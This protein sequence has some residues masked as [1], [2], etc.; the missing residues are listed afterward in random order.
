MFRCHV[1]QHLVQTSLQ[2]NDMAQALKYIVVSLLIKTI[3]LWTLDSNPSSVFYSGQDF[4]SFK[5]EIP[6]Y[7]FEW[8]RLFVMNLHMDWVTAVVFLFSFIFVN[9]ICILYSEDNT[10]LILWSKI[11]LMKNNYIISCYITEVYMHDQYSSLQSSSGRMAMC[12]SF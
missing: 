10:H 1:N 5:M 8:L 3:D 2:W 12:C 9:S 6:R 11:K 7:F 4:K